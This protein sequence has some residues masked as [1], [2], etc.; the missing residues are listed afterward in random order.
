MYR[1]LLP[2]AAE[3]ARARAQIESVLELPQA[4]SAV[5]V[6]V[7]HV[8]DDVSTPDA[9]WAAGG[10]TETYEEEMD[11][12]RELQRLPDSVAAVVDALEEGDL[13]FAVHEATGEPAE[14]IRSYADERNSDVIVVGVG[15]RSPVG[16]ALFG[17]VAQAV[18]L[19]SDRPV[20]V[21]PESAGDSSH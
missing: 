11:E 16:K 1:V 14:L 10:F 8:H 2:V 5:F 15:K 20:T 4:D 9:E 3:T 7:L 18:I 17:S 13:E 12:L 6:D 19:E 21:V